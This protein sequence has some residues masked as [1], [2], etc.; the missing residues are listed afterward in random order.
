MAYGGSQ[1]RGLIGAE[2]ASLCHSHSNAG[3]KAR[4]QPTPQ[5]TAMPDPQPTEKGQGLNLHPHGCWTG[6]STTDGNSSKVNLN[7]RNKN[8]DTLI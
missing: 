7:I 3:F 1:A 2:D 8:I 4:L 5:H 6:S